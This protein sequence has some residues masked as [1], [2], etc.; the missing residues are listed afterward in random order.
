MNMITITAVSDG[1]SVSQ[2]VPAFGTKAA[3]S[4][5]VLPSFSQPA[6]CTCPGCEGDDACRAGVGTRAAPSVC[7]VSRSQLHARAVAGV[8]QHCHSQR[9][10]PPSTDISVQAGVPASSTGPQHDSLSAPSASV[11]TPPSFPCSDAPRPDLTIT[12]LSP[13]NRAPSR[14]AKMCAAL[15]SA[16]CDAALPTIS[17]S[18]SGSS[19]GSVASIVKR[20]GGTRPCIDIPCGDGCD[21]Q[22]C[23]IPCVVM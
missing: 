21:C 1:T 11:T 5:P 9:P 3:P 13:A 22:F 8:G 10:P 23:C 17:G 18:S 2:A 19:G 15:S 6:A 7:P 20:P 16:P 4:V 12:R 14:S